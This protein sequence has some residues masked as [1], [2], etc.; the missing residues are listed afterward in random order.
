MLCLPG[1]GTHANTQNL[2]HFHA[3]PGSIQERCLPKWLFFM[4][5]AKLPNRPGFALLPVHLQ[6]RDLSGPLNRLNAKLSL[7]HPLQPL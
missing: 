6:R 4:A 2:P 5:S 7:L 3:F 1:F